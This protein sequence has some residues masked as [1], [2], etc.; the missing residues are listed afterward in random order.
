MSRVM[1]GGLHIFSQEGVPVLV[2]VAFWM[3]LL[4]GELGL[5]ASLVRLIQRVADWGF[6]H[7]GDQLAEG[8]LATSGP[9]ADW[10]GP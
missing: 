9:W 7:G 4:C 6:V 1:G 5:G 3:T 2:S 10:P 8:L